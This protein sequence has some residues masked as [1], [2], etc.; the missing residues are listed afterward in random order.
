MLEPLAPDHVAEIAAA[1]QG[2]RA[3]FRYTF[4]PDGP[5]E[6]ADYVE[7]LL[8]E[9]AEGRIAPFVQRRADD[10][11]VVGCTRFMNPAWPLARTDPDEVEIGGTW[12][13]P[14]AQR[15]GINTDAKLLLLTHAF[16]RWEVQRVAICTDALN[17]R[18]R[19]AIERLGAVCEGVLRRHRAIVRAAGRTPAP[20][21]RDVLD[22]RRRVARRPRAPPVGG[23]RRDG[24]LS[25]AGARRRRPS[26]PHQLLPRPRRAGSR[27]TARCRP[28]RRDARSVR[29]A[30]GTGNDGGGT[31]RLS[32]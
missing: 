22:R 3:S 30:R 32:R 14:D 27:R 17:E 6:A 20:R 7:G 12:L 29:L 10:G 24:S 4:V 23:S 2:D 13:S 19:R 11:R 21:Q 16:E 31:A 28:R 1:G 8:A 18:S 15:T 5:D 9:A 26:L 25:R